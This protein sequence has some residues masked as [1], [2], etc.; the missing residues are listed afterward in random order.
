[1]PA[2]AADALREDAVRVEPRGMNR[3]LIGNY[4]LASQVAKTSTAA[5]GNVRGHVQTLFILSLKKCCRCCDART[6]G[7]ATATDTLRE[8]TIRLTFVS[9]D[10]PGIRDGN[11]APDAAVS[12]AAANGNHRV[13][14]LFAPSRDRT[15]K[16]EPSVAAFPTDA[17]R[18]DGMGA[19][20]KR[21]DQAVVLHLDV[22]TLIPKAAFTADGYI[23]V[24]RCLC[25]SRERPGHGK[26]TVAAKP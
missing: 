15:G 10:V 18:K 14:I 24:Y 13:K 12:C 2:A 17:L 16:G 8:H 20:F 9:D 7:S 5:K 22:A 1:L 6:A 4:D 19:L 25:R 3:A 26:A 11:L 23:D 21:F